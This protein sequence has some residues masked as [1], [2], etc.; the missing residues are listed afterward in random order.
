MTELASPVTYLDTDKAWD[1]LAS[2]QLGRL[3]VQ[4]DVGVDIFPVNY[5][6][7]GE[8]IIFRTAEGAK[9]SDLMAFGLATFEVDMWDEQCGY[10]VIAKGPA[11]PVRAVEEIAEVEALH[12]RPWVPTVKTVFV[13]I[14]VTSISARKFEFGPDPIEKYR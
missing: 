14:C 8:C 3:A 13:R 11:T 4:A 9:L 6:I 7:D 1:L 5:A 2:G 10:S 12:L